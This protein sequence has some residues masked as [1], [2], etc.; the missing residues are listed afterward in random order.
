MTTVTIGGREFVLG[1]LYAPA[2]PISHNG[3]QRGPRRLAGYDPP[4]RCDPWYAERGG[5]VRVRHLSGSLGPFWSGDYWIAWIGEK[6]E[7]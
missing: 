7:G 4:E 5:R 1:A 2:E 6:V 3:K